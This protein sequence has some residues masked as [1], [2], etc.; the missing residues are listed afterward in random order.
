MYGKQLADGDKTDDLE[1]DDNDDERDV[2][3]DE[4]GYIQISSNLVLHHKPHGVR[5]IKDQMNVGLK[6]YS[7]E[8]ANGD[9]ADNKDIHEDEDMN[10]DVVDVNG[11]TNR[12]YGSRVPTA[13]FEG[14]TAGNLNISNV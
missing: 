4:N 10:D 3:V 9:S 8:L 14:N 7:D 12:G 1:L 5:M 6:D 11:Q 13:Y 2:N